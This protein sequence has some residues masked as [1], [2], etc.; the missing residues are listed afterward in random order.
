MERVTFLNAIDLF[1]VHPGPS[2]TENKGV[3]P[4]A[5]PDVPDG[6]SLASVPW[7]GA[8]E[9]AHALLSWY[10]S[11]PKTFAEVKRRGV[12]N[13]HSY[14]APD[15][16]HLSQDGYHLLEEEVDMWRKRIS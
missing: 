2:E 9:S 5:A 7:S 8:L 16:L 3:S 6:P 12:E 11:D 15:R 1:T 14:W 10:L 4:S 13:G